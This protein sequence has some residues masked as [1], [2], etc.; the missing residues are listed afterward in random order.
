MPP[1][2]VRVPRRLPLLEA[3]VRLPLILVRQKQLQVPDPVR[4]PGKPGLFVVR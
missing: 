4:Q 3:R 2:V 1:T